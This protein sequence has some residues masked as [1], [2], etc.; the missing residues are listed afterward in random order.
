MRKAT[1]GAGV[2]LMALSAAATVAAGQP[3]PPPVVPEIDGGSLTIGL[4]LLSGS[5][6]ILRSRWRSK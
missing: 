1:Y 3:T 6:M 2:L 4:G 5:L